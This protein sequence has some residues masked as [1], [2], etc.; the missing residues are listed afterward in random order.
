MGPLVGFRRAVDSDL[1]GEYAVFAAAQ[2]ELHNRRGA[3]WS[4]PPFDP[5]GMWVQVH[6]HL[7]SHDGERSFVAEADGRIVGFTAALV[8]GDCWFFSALFIDPAYQ[9]QGIGQRRSTSDSASAI[10]IIHGIG[11]QK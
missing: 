10:S 4:A 3:V 6:R 1:A 11:A 2:E 9:G 5:D 7:L 8:R